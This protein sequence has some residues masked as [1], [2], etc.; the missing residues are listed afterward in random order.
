LIKGEIKMESLSVEC[1][2]A[3]VVR[4]EVEENAARIYAGLV[5]YHGF[6]MTIDQKEKAIKSSVEAAI[7]LRK[8][9]D[10]AIVAKPYCSHPLE[11]GV[12]MNSEL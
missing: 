7:A 10:N 6:S 5:G 1:Y 3:Y 4:R 9:I 11:E 2:N 8:E 12:K